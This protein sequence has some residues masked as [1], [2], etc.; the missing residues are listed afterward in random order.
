MYR[1]IFLV[2]AVIMYLYN[3]KHK[4]KLHVGIL[5]SLSDKVMSKVEKPLADL[6]MAGIKYFNKSQDNYEIIPHIYD[7]KGDNTLFK[8]YSEILCKD[9][10]II[11]IFGCWTSSSRKTV[12]PIV[13]K[14][15]QLLF[16]PIQY[17]GMECSKNIFYFGACPN[18]Q[19]A[20]GI[21]YAIKNLNS[22]LYLIGSDYVFPRTANEIVKQ[23]IK[24]YNATLLNEIYVSM[25]ELN[26]DKISSDIITKYPDG[27][28]IVNTIN[29]ASN[30][31]FFETLYNK[32]II[33]NSD[34]IL[35]HDKYK[36]I[37]FSIPE[38]QNF[39]IDT[40]SLFNSY[41]VW[42]FVQ[43]ETIDEEKNKLP[44]HNILKG[45]TD[46]FLNLNY[47]VG[48]P[49]FHSFLSFYYFIYF[50]LTF[51]NTNNHDPLYLRN[52]IKHHINFEFKFKHKT[53]KIKE[54]NHLEQPVFIV[55]IDKNRRYNIIYKTPGNIT[56][57]PWLIPFTTQT[58]YACDNSIKFLGSKYIIN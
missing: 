54:N 22:K 41:A 27:C 5:H 29:G 55:Q 14:Y 36:I 39:D 17:E 26:F 33:T 35:F 16:Y 11:L 38:P 1:I 24:K 43:S 47:V 15:N 6:L 4:R 50:I 42:N 52:K 51:N 37:S 9:P 10:K 57:N 28:L 49:E 23:Y 18:Q 8:K 31:A 34:K 12:L 3:K 32:Y 2:I 45:L 21:E 25:D 40:A 53:F 56:P 19:I 13:E 44:Q 20:V 7:T 30:K 48:D 46:L 58:K